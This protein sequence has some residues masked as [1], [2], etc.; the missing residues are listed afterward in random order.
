M[1]Q[2]CLAI[3]IAQDKIGFVHYDLTPWNIIL[4]PS[5]N[6]VFDYVLRDT[7]II[8]IKTNL[9]PV[10]IDYGKSHVIV[11]Q[12]HHGFINM[13][14]V[15]T[16]QDM[17]SLMLI[18]VGVIIEKQRLSK[19]DFNS[20]LQLA[21]FISGTQYR[22]DKFTTAFSV[23]EFLQITTK[24][25]TL[26]TSDKYELE[27]LRPYDMFTW[28]M[29]IG[30]TAKYNFTHDVQAVNRVDRKMIMGN[31][32]Q[33]FE[34]I[35]SSSIEEKA[36][37]Y[38]NVFMRLKHC[39]IP[40]PDNIFFVYYAVQE[41]SRNIASVGEQ[42]EIFLD[43]TSRARPET[44]SSDGSPMARDTYRKAYKNCMDFL[45]SVYN[46]K[47]DRA[48]FQPVTY[49]IEGDFS[50]LEKASYT[51]ESFL[52]PSFIKN[53]LGEGKVSEDLSKYHEI[54]TSVFLDDGPYK[55]DKA[56]KAD[57]QK[58][59]KK[60]L[61]ID[62]LIM[63]NNTANLNTLRELSEKI[64]SHDLKILMNELPGVGDC[65]DARKYLKLYSSIVNT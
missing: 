39:T 20:L 2:I 62:P 15:S 40:Q 29:N 17:L 63:K 5:K 64:Y 56:V 13:F 3:Q 12:K 18:S 65:S 57:Y 8:R 55:L 30:K 7:S 1:I 43:R 16:I 23:K 48:E 59:F 60:L 27:K 47:I 14:K 31:S 25:S 41:L 24:Y 33:I 38:F 35:L 37:T 46:P 42:M 45:N 9:V 61:S 36:Q 58:N 32:R 51:E 49:N 54:I 44:E 19:T 52:D 6:A 4:Q 22:R 28:I 34:F 11:N 10:I 50:S 53:I 21:N 26:I